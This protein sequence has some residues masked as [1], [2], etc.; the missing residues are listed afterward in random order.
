[1]TDE[2]IFIEVVISNEEALLDQVVLNREAIKSSTG[3]FEEKSSGP[4]D[5]CVLGVD[6]AFLN[7]IRRLL[8]SQDRIKDLGKRINWA[9]RFAD[10]D[11]FPD[12]LR[13]C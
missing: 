7:E 1:M 2:E 6:D 5:E 13:N 9:E 12:R 11:C 10:C 4:Q 8:W 3:L